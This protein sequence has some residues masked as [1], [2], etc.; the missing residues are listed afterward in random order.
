MVLYVSVNSYLFSPMP[1]ATG[2]EHSPVPILVITEKGAGG[3]SCRSRA[4]HCHFHSHKTAGSSG[5]LSKCESEGHLLVLLPLLSPSSLLF[6]LSE[7]PQLRNRIVAQQV[8]GCHPEKNS[9]AADKSPGSIS[10]F[11]RIIHFWL[12]DRGK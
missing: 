3:I 4:K 2:L 8:A 12:A 1:Q 10:C 5:S 7:E 6:N 11:S 9:S